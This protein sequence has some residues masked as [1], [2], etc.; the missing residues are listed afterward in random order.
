V[1]GVSMLGTLLLAAATA[2]GASAAKVLEITEGGNPVA[3]GTP[4]FA[5]IAIV[6]CVSYTEGKVIVNGKGKD[7]VGFKGSPAAECNG[8]D[9]LSGGITEASIS[10]SGTAAYKAKLTV[11]EEGPCVYEVTK[12]TVDYTVPGKALT[13]GEANA[14][15]NKKAS[16]LTCAKTQELPLETDIANGVFGA[17][18]GLEDR[19]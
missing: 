8:E 16:S 13:H 2:S 4:A 15:L 7:K 1:L 6:G 17:P 18:F 10:T 3:K 19:A 12:F 11:S 5:G 9:T 14:K